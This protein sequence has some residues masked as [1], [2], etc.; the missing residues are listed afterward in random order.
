MTNYGSFEG[1]DDWEA[2]G[3]TAVTR[4]NDP[5]VKELLRACSAGER[6][7]VHYS[8][9]EGPPRQR[10]IRP[11]AVYAKHGYSAIYVE[12]FCEL[13]RDDRVFRT[14][15]MRLVTKAG[16][17]SPKATGIVDAAQPA[18]EPRNRLATSAPVEAVP[19][20]HSRRGTARGAKATRTK[21]AWQR[22][23]RFVSY[24]LDC[25]R[26]DEGF[27]V[28]VRLKDAGDKWLP[29]L[30]HQEWSA[31]GEDSLVVSLTEAD[32]PFAS[33]VLQS[34]A[35][36]S[37]LYGYPIAVLDGRDGNT[38]MFPV[39]VLP[40][41]HSIQ[42]SIL[43]IAR[44]DDWPR[45]NPSPTEA[46]G[47]RAEE[48][49]ALLDGLGL[50][51]SDAEPPE[52]GL[53][54]LG[55][56]LEELQVLGEVAEVIDPQALNTP[57][58]RPIEVG[59]AGIFNWSGLFFS[60][61]PTYTKSLERELAQ[62]RDFV[63][64]ED[65]AE[66]ALRF[67]FDPDVVTRDIRGRQGR[68]DVIVVSPLNEAQVQSVAAGL[69]SS[70]T[71]VT[72]PPGTGKSQV[73]VNLLANA[74][75]AGQ[76]VLFSSRNNKAVEVVE[77]RTSALSRGRLLL[78]AGSRYSNRD[79]RAE[80]VKF[81]T[82]VLATQAGEVERA[83]ARRLRDR[84]EVI[85][86][87][88]ESVLD[89]LERVRVARDRVNELDILIAPLLQALPLRR[90]KQLKLL[91][92]D[93]MLGK[94]TKVI[95]S[96]PIE[97][98]DVPIAPA[99]EHINWFRHLRNKGVARKAINLLR[100]YE[101]LIPE[102]LRVESLAHVRREDLG[103]GIDEL[104]RTLG[105]AASLS[106]YKQAFELLMEAGSPVP[107]AE[108]MLQ[109]ENDALDLGRALVDT[110]GDLV[111]AR[112][113]SSSRRALGELKA[114]MERLSGER[115][116]SSAYAKL[117]AELNR[118]FPRVTRAVPLWC[119]TNLSVG[120]TFPLG[121]GLFDLV[122]IDE[123]GQCDIPSAIPLLYRAE[124]AM[125]I[126]DPNQLR[127]ISKLAKS[128]DRQ[129]Q[130]VYD[131]ENTSDQP[132]AFGTNSLF[133][134]ASS[135]AVG[136]R[137]AELIEH[138]R[139][140]E[141]I[142][143]FSNSQ[144]YGGRLRVCT[145][146]EHLMSVPGGLGVEWTDAGASSTSRS[147]A[148]RNTAPEEAAAIV[149][150]LCDLA[151]TPD[152]RGSLGVVTPFRAQANLIKRLVNERLEIDQIQRTDLIVD[153]AH[154]FQGDERDVVFL[155]PCVNRDLSAGGRLFLTHT[156]NLFN[157]AITRARSRLHVVGDL[158]GC[159]NCGIEYVERFA[160]EYGPVS[161]RMRDEHLPWVASQDNVGYY[162]RPLYQ[163]LVAEGLKPIPQYSEG[164][165]KLDLA[166]VL[167]GLKLDVEV[168]GEYFHSTWSGDQARLDL[169]RDIRLIERG[170]KIKRFW[171]QEVRDDVERCAQEVLALVEASSG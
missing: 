115:L 59:E 23:N 60:D 97:S 86:N 43:K 117:R 64:E 99:N 139:S 79:F 107:L 72:G 67:F 9:G 127:H 171:A 106:E 74:L 61:R 152:F 14:D 146:Y 12:A 163:A 102:L 6:V 101:E 138:F 11:R 58:G 46:L 34:T 53:G 84:L 116:E 17:G 19:S 95:G 78:R 45:L 82:H 100:A 32:T 20:Q 4:S 57:T 25:I 35:S 157:V 125:I 119:V 109:L 5:L 81:L 156:E 41:D 40:V 44:A 62:L 158:N 3:R 150:L 2:S 153:T 130:H 165:Y 77:A 154:G 170:W 167:D 85:K 135:S 96:D 137:V 66:S 145:D 141:D 52:G 76:S 47:L 147:R 160:A 120:G 103:R 27:G 142:V 92:R 104:R 56:R 33:Y 24:Y 93:E 110:E 7:C 121:A 51:L 136:V 129:L 111:A 69:D 140:H 155:S 63:S 133:D 75:L 39:F 37:L 90:R 55:L 29:L 118:V 168:D 144:W 10:W 89:R 114:T 65:L 132:Y 26:E 91:A 164:P 30:G 161:R 94:A 68:N 159:L 50:G 112:L 98:P 123:A 1:L 113:D 126:G 80:I 88:Q 143:R 166:L 70:V 13:R 48:T 54:A 15:R 148:Q 18:V 108:Q 124:K 151:A 131:L 31:S 128:R 162:E 21:P 8:A 49:R 22:F 38:T 134:L 36:T 169:R 73:V 83:E 28:A 42:G 87:Q 16:E 71:V 122:V 149:D 105:L